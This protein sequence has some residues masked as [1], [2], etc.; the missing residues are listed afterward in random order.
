MSKSR[1]NWYKYA[2]P[3]NFYPLAGKMIPV[4]AVLSVIAMV[5]GLYLGFF[6]APAQDAQQHEYYRIIFVHVPAAWMGMFLYVLLAIYAGVG[7]AFNA[8]LGSMMATAIAP[9]GA[10][11]TFI[12]LVTGSLWG[13]PAWGVYWVW[14]AR[15]TSTLILM[16]LYIGFISLQSSIEDPRRADRAGAVLALV[17]VVNVPIIYFSVQWW[18][19]LHQGATITATSFKMASSMRPALLIMVAGFWIY[20]IAV[21][22]ARVRCIILER[23]SEA[24]WLAE[25][26]ASA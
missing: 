4:F 20:S 23:E 7:W 10:I 22:L 16:F 17:G 6:V 3:V 1:L 14:D 13:R 5:V 19:T 8:R 25:P 18:N 12:S 15:M 24:P 26:V 21:V 2:A 9:T 11:F